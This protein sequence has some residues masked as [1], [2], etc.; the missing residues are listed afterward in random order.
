MSSY[1][2]SWEYPNVQAKTVNTNQI[3]ALQKE[4]Q[5]DFNKKMCIY[6]SYNIAGAS[7]S[8]K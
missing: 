1:F 4:E 3:C 6:M 7:Y 8:P 2:W 5:K